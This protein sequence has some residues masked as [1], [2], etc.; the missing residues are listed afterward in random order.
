M[1]NKEPETDSCQPIAQYQNVNIMSSLIHLFTV[2]GRHFSHS[3]V[4]REVRSD[5]AESQDAIGAL[6]RIQE[7]TSENL[8]LQSYLYVSVPDGTDLQKGRIEYA[9][10]RKT[11]RARGRAA[12]R[13]AREAR[14]R[15]ISEM[16]GFNRQVVKEVGSVGMN[17]TAFRV[18]FALL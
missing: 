8:N 4:G 14:R 17:A 5:I 6:L 7:A 12:R 10:V 16:R 2:E 15:N 1:G 18:D 9:G 13:K 11:V 3:S